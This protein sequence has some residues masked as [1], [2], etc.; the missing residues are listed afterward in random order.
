MLPIVDVNDGKVVIVLLVVAI[1]LVF[2][3]NISGVDVI[4]LDTT[5]GMVGPWNGILNCS[6][7]FYSLC[8]ILM[9]FYPLVTYVSIFT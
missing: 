9:L 5:V 6:N 2:S 3:G 8:S 7:S 4:V 1:I